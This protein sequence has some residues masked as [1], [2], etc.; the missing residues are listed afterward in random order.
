MREWINV[1]P[2][3][4]E[5]DGAE[6]PSLSLPSGS[7]LDSWRIAIGRRL[8]MLLTGPQ[9]AID[10][11]LDDIER[12]IRQPGHLVECDGRFGLPSACATLVLINVDALDKPRQF[13]VLRWL[14]DPQHTETQ[15]ISLTTTSLYS[16]VQAETFDSALYY[17]LNV[18]FF[19]IF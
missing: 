18:F 13:Q 16:R 9:A 15:V 7:Y 3:S 8:N 11:S 17:R 19:E 4:R 6:Q 10:Q 14:N 12:L 2:D 5:I 1:S